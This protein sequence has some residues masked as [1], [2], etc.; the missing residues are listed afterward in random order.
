MASI[1]SGPSSQML[2]PAKF[3][4][5]NRR[6][7]TVSI[8]AAALIAHAVLLG[9]VAWSEWTGQADVQTAADEIPV[10]MATPEEAEGR[11]GPQQAKPASPPAAIEP[12]DVGSD[13]TPAA[14]QPAA[15]A[16]SDGKVVERPKESD[17]PQAA[18]TRGAD[19]KPPER[20]DET[21]N[22]FGGLTAVET[23]APAERLPTFAAPQSMMTAARPRPAQD[24]T[25]DNYR[26][27]V[28]G[29]V[30]AN[31]ID[32]ERPRPKALAI[33]GF[34]VDAQG[35]LESVWLARPSGHADLD[36]EAVDMVRR[37]AP[38]PAPPAGADRNFGAAIAFGEEG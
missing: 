37:S 21:G 18:R 9:L 20:Q 30:A 19:A 6:A 13:K 4:E 1:E 12:R 2:A 35:G 7:R 23:P 27:K 3:I 24:P 10:E 26:A 8:V 33:V 36:A 31:M 32:P 22:P 28:L 14:Q 34:R 16:T 17:R 25:N 5:R 29:K 38:F 11:A 15:A